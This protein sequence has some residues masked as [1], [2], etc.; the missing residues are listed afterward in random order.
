[1]VD[2]PAAPAEPG[3]AADPPPAFGA[4]LEGDLKGYIETKGFKDLGALATS[5]QNLEKLRGVPEDQL[6]R[7]PDDPTKAGAMD[8]VYAK[9]G[10]PEA[11]D[12]YT[13]VL[14][15]GFDVETYK[16]VSERAHMLGLGDGQFQ[17]LQEIMQQQSTQMLEVQDA[18]N[19]A[20]FDAWKE[21]N[22]TG[23]NDAARIMASVGMSEDAVEAMLTGD[24]TAIY[25]FAAKIGARTAEQ[26][27]IHGDAPNDGGFNVSPAAAKVKIADLMADDAF[28]NQYTNPS[29]AVRQ[30][31]IDRL[32]KL[33]E[34]AAQYKD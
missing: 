21:K 33:H 24:K 11:A 1:M 31:A 27:V 9:M 7:L 4:E 16:V 25:D 2:D 17:G 29:K 23:F 34:T 18:E 19:T 6:I 20:A 5:Y 10:R 32:S 14:G 15:D 8:P 3:Q 22:P 30:V 12:K 26:N 13:N 28:M